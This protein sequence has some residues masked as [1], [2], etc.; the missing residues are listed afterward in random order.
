MSLL[1][2]IMDYHGFIMKYY[3]LS[4]VYYEIL[5]IIMS[6]KYLDNWKS[7]ASEFNIVSILKCRNALGFA[8]TS[9][10]QL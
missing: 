3:G 5:W 6:H 2:N 8:F 1:W 7:Y 10:T 4:W 9:P